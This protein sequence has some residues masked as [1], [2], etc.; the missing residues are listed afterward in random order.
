LI[1]NKKDKVM[2]RI[3]KYA[4]LTRN[5]RNGEHFEFFLEIIEFIL[6]HLSALG[7]TVK[8]WDILYNTF[9]KEDEIYKRSRKAAETRYIT[10]AHT[11]RLNAFRVVKGGVETASYK[12]TPADKQ[13][14]ERLAFVL[15]NFR[16]I[17]KASLVE[18]SALI[19]NMIQDLRRTAYAPSVQTLG[20]TEAVN[21]LEE[22]NEEFKAL[23]EEREMELK[24]AETL[25]NM[26]YIR[27][28]TDKAFATFTEAL[29]SFY[30]LA[31]LNGKT[32]EADALNQLINRINATISQYETILAHR[33]GSAGKG[34]PGG[35]GDDDDNGGYLPEEPG[36][37]TPSLA[38]ASQEAPSTTVMYVF[39]ADVAAFTQALYPAAQGG[40]L[41]LEQAGETP[42]LCPITGFRTV[43]E[44][45]VDVIAGLEVA[46]PSANRTFFSPFDNDGPCEAWVEKDGETLA[47]FTGMAYPGMITMEPD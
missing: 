14:A 20:L 26:R 39:P 15:D 45:G 5:L 25:G 40:V 17:S 3:E 12:D 28:L 44:N 34:K 24:E 9:Q 31:R 4:N 6:K 18:A 21:T 47:R 33:G 8:L 43:K 36:D 23:Y 41:T 32:A 38:V 42:A 2:N 46:S 13:A 27:P 19:F 11:K 16:N 29:N 22:R 35:G 30:A 10:E 1:T 7:D 37:E